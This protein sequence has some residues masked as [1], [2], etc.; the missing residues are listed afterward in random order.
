MKCNRCGAPAVET[1]W[2]RDK[3]GLDHVTLC[4]KCIDKEKPFN[5]PDY[6]DSEEVDDDF[7]IH[8]W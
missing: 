4:P 6:I 1:F 2:F 8:S 5:D 7:S 3:W